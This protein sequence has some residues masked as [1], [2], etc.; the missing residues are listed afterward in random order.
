MR[1]VAFGS[2][3]TLWL[4]RRTGLERWAPPGHGRAAPPRPDLTYTAQKHGLAADHVTALA[5]RATSQG[6]E[7]WIGSSAGV[8]RYQTWQE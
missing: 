6:D 2:E 4:G 8:S 3:G 5:V 1:A 7:V